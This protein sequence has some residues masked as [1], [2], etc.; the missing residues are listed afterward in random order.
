MAGVIVVPE[1]E[2]YEKVDGEKIEAIFAEV[3][4]SEDLTDEIVGRACALAEEGAR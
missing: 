4:L 3:S 2:H 1:G